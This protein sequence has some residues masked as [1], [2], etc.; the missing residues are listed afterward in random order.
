MEPQDKIALKEVVELVSKKIRQEEENQI[1]LES[2][3]DVLGTLRKAADNL[4]RRHD[5][6]ASVTK[7]IERI[8]KN[9]DSCMT[10]AR[11]LTD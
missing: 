4:L 1:E 7:E 5:R 10:R 11:N 6:Q 8:I 2:L 3:A 9:Y